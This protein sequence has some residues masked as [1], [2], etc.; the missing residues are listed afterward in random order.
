LAQQGNAAHAERAGA[1]AGRPSNGPSSE[2]ARLLEPFYKRVHDLT[3]YHANIFAYYCPS[4]ALC[5]KH[6]QLT[7]LPHWKVLGAP[8]HD[9]AAPAGPRPLRRTPGTRAGPATG[10]I[11]VYEPGG[12]GWKRWSIGRRPR[13]SYSGRR[14]FSAMARPFY[15]ARKTGEG[16]E[17]CVST[18]G[19]LRVQPTGWC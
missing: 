2:P 1:L 4:H 9:G 5:S 11:T 12:G 18:R 15:R 13:V 17:W 7:F 3:C 19:I 14:W 10:P 8:E 16:R 6:P